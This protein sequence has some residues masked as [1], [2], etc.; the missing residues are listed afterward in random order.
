MEAEREWVGV[1]VSGGGCRGTLGGGQLAV[2]HVWL[3][4]LLPFILMLLHLSSRLTPSPLHSAHMEI[5]QVFF[6]IGPARRGPLYSAHQ[7]PHCSRGLTLKDSLILS[8]TTA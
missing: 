2:E 8:D 3:P 6:Q 5:S 4:L 7:S 1:V